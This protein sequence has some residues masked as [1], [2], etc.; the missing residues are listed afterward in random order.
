MSRHPLL[1]STSIRLAVL[2]LAA[3]C[4]D[5]RGA[6]DGPGGGRG[7]GPGGPGN[8]GGNDRP[9]PV[10]VVTVG[11]GTV[12][13]TSTVA[14]ILEP[15]RAVGVNAQLSG[16]LLSVRVEEGNYVREG[17]VLAQIDARELEAQV[18][19]AE[20]SLELAESTAKRSDE[21][22]RQQIITAAEYERDRAALAS[23]TATLEQLRTRLGYAT[24]RA[25]MSGVITEK[26]VETGDIVSPQTRIFSIAD[27]SVLVARAMVSELDV[28]LLQRGGTVDVTVD[29]LGGARVPGRI[30]RVFPTADSTTRLVPVEVALTGSS[31]AQLRPGY[32]VRVTFRLGARDDAL[33][34]PTRAVMGPAGARTV[35]IVHGGMGVR[36]PVRVG[37]DIDG[38]TEVFDG[39]VVGDSVIVAGHMLLREGAAVRVVP[40]LSP[41]ESSVDAPNPARTESV[42]ARPA[43]VRRSE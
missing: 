11:R 27:V 2:V 37:P 22:Y 10:E 13:R 40:P 42:T 8:R 30:R 41:L 18:K 43:T 7:G 26:R 34:I 31:L 23:A 20:A 12:A 16:P 29:A 25:P 36:R 38:Q 6:A 35:M 15:L 9:T 17:Q 14:S 3:A 4:G 1:Y 19:S 5:A 32:T 33:L 39:L 24:L 28:P 21:L